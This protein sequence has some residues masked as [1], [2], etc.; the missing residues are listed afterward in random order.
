[1]KNNPEQHQTD[2]QPVLKQAV[3]QFG[4]YS[5]FTVI[6]A[7][8]MMMAMTVVLLF[9]NKSMAVLISV[10]LLFLKYLIYFHSHI[11]F[12]VSTKALTAVVT[13]FIR[14]QVAEIAVA[15]VVANFVFI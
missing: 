4:Y 12:I 3:Y 10:S 11:F 13:Y 5:L 9:N 2:K 7:A 1:M 6:T 8:V 14:I 15:T